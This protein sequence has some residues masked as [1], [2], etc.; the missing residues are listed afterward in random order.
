MREVSSF[1]LIFLIAFQYIFKDDGFFSQII[2]VSIFKK[3]VFECAE[4]CEF[5]LSMYGN[6]KKER[7]HCFHTTLHKGKLK[8]LCLNEI[9]ILYT[10]C[11]FIEKIHLYIGK[12]HVVVRLQYKHAS[13]IIILRERSLLTG[14]WLAIFSVM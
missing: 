4:A 5:V 6:K 9:N 3:F 12:I 11:M 10:F 1:I 13:Y 8:S 14:G 2:G 7:L